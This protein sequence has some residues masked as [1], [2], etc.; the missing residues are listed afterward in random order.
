MCNEFVIR[1]MNGITKI[2]LRNQRLH[3]QSRWSLHDSQQ[4]VLHRLPVIR[5][6]VVATE[7]P[8]GARRFASQESLRLVPLLK[9]LIF[10]M[11]SNG[12]S[13]SSA[14]GVGAGA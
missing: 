8:K 12:L 2:I 6:T 3:L 11:V 4:M 1:D 9:P 5:W 14:S 7:E 10:E 13:A